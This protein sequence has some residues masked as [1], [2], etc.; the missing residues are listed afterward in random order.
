MVDPSS[1][2][3]ARGSQQLSCLNQ[4]RDQTPTC[5]SDQAPSRPP[6]QPTVRMRIKSATSATPSSEVQK[7]SA[8]LKTGVF[9]WMLII[10]ILCNLYLWYTAYN[11]VVLAHSSNTT[12]FAHHFCAET[13]K[14]LS[15]TSAPDALDRWEYIRMVDCHYAYD[16]SLLHS[17]MCDNLRGRLHLPI[18][19]SETPT[20]SAPTPGHH[21]GGQDDVN[22]TGQIAG[23]F[24]DLARTSA[25]ISEAFAMAENCTIASNA[26][27]RRI[28]DRLIQ[29]TH[30]A[31]FHADRASLH[32]DQ[33]AKLR[34]SWSHETRA[35]TQQAVQ[36][37][38]SSDTIANSY[39]IGDLE[40]RLRD[41]FLDHLARDRKIK[42]SLHNHQ[43]DK[44]LQEDDDAAVRPSVTS[45]ITP[46]DDLVLWM[47]NLW[48][49]ERWL[50]VLEDWLTARGYS[51]T[52][53]GEV[54]H[55]RTRAWE[56]RRQLN[57]LL[58]V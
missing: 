35:M 58:V 54:K 12:I 31:Q 32:I 19:L 20:H 56:V 8:T 33:I 2:K 55:S 6:A 49:V 21:Q 45:R 13:V 10:S 38:N 53:V 46:H 37:C 26:P 57:T 42:L 27:M 17:A 25:Q 7:T 51:K 34:Y 48:W 23:F 16:N 47:Q 1:L 44:L 40:R 18:Q 52:A 50:R 4:F 11:S 9:V 39:L 22:I 14:P 28:Y 5:L 43:Y 30:W 15:E 24:H 29:S 41:T 3:N 36:L